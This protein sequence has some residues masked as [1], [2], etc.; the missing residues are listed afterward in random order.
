MAQRKQALGDMPLWPTTRRSTTRTPRTSGCVRPGRTPRTRPTPI[1]SPRVGTHPHPVTAVG[2]RA[3]T[4]RCCS[5]RWPM[6][7][8]RWPGSTPA[9]RPRPARSARGCCARLALTEAAGFLAHTHVWVHPLDLALRDAGLTAP[10]ALAAL[11]AGARALPHTHRP[12]GRAPRLGGSAA[13]DPAGG[14]PGRRRCAGTGPSA[15]PPA[16]WRAA[17]VRQ[18]RGHRRD[19]DSARGAP[20]RPRSAGGL[21]G[22]AR[23]SVAAPATVR[24]QARGG[25]GATPAAARRRRCR[26]GLDGERHHRSGGPGAGAARRLRPAGP[27]GAGAP[28]CSCR[29]GAPTRRSASATAMHCRRCAPTPPIASSAGVGR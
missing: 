12:A 27:A 2:A 14:R 28:A 5:R 26:P 18:R 3:P 23:A 25:Q 13:R 8:M 17:P 16:G 24:R 11:G 29:S 6:P 19:A 7:V 10:A 15:P 21:V 9:S 1:V 4:C 22:R 20:P